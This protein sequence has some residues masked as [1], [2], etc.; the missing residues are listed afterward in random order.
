MVLEIGTCFTTTLHIELK[1]IWGNI[2]GFVVRIL[3]EFSAVFSS[4]KTQGQNSQV[5][6]IPICNIINIM[7]LSARLILSYLLFNFLR[8]CAVSYL[9]YLLTH[10]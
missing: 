5:S 9:G 1:K 7:T 10:F 6:K 8:S 3:L 4:V 2:G